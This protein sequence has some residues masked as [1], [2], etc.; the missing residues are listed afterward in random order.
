MKAG[1]DP[2][3]LADRELEDSRQMFK[4]K[5]IGLSVRKIVVNLHSEAESLR[6]F[7]DPG[8]WFAAE[9]DD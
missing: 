3:Y 4:N 8:G 6:S 2:A 5:W 1:N 7:P 9:I